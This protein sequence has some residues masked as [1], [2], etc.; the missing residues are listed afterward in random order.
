[1]REYPRKIIDLMSRSISL[2]IQNCHEQ[3]LECLDEVTRIHP[4]FLPVLIEKGIILGE[5]GRYEESVEFFDRFLQVLP[6]LSQVRLLRDNTLHDALAHYD[7]LL[8]VNPGN[9]ALSIERGDI[10]QKLRRYAEAV[11][12]YNRALEID[13]NSIDALNRRGNAFLELNRHEDSLESYDLALTIDPGNALVLFN[14]GNVL[15]QLGKMDEAL[16]NYSRALEFEPG[17]V[18]AIIEQ[19]HCGLAMGDYRTGWRQYESRWKSD[20]LKDSRL[21]STSPLWLG[22]EDLAGKTILLWSEQG[23]GDTIQFLR[24]VPL[25]AQKAGRVILRV[26]EALRSLS[27]TLKSSA[28]IIGDEDVLPSHDFHCP[29]MSMPLA[30]GTTLESIPADIP[31][32]RANADQVEVWRN[33][34]GPGPGPRV[35][36]V[37]AGRQYGLRNGT[38]DIR[39]EILRPLSQLNVDI[40]SLQ[41]TIPEE[42]RNAVAAL[43]QFRWIGEALTDFADTAALISNLDIVISVD[44]S[45][46]HLAG[47]LGKPV[48]ILLRHSGEWRW[49]WGRGDSPWYPTARIFR[50]KIRG[51][52]AG[53]VDEVTDQMR[54]WISKG[55]AE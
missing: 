14:K 5:L 3:A 52:W 10:L 27:G 29:L 9:P 48:W 34:L 38:R 32:L 20:Q 22:E 51:D 31:Y 40:I 50:Q 8:A 26:P 7:G 11:D 49:L 46:A 33:R 47:A 28:A 23:L 54:L 12:S 18:E 45:V 1:M 17:L 36:L 55:P 4:D 25:A 35:G 6:D 53:V 24:Y 42:D 37:W 44:T 19:S 21:D 43:P 2:R 13:G 30:F 39:L 15:Q 41:K 16:D